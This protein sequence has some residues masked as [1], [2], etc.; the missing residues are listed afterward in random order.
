MVYN[1]A[2][3]P[4]TID[5][6]FV[7]EKRFRKVEIDMSKWMEEMPDGVPSIV[8]I[9]PGETK[10]D[11]YVAVTT[12]EDNILTW[13]IL[14]SD[15]GA[16]EGTGMAQIW[17]EEEAN[18]SVYKRGKSVLVATQIHGS[19]NEA[20]STVPSSQTAFVEQVT[21]LKTQAVN[22]KTAAETAQAAAETAQVAAETAAGIAIA[23][24]GKLKFNIDEN[25]HLIMS[26][27]DEVPIEGV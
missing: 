8:H 13:Q 19:I 4:S 15:L 23:Q 26:Y 9:R 10:A 24:A 22:A 12:F 20:S 25:G 11:A 27:T 21:S 2:N 14:D 6:G 5:I 7:G 17:L 16:S 1:I 3:M 18:S